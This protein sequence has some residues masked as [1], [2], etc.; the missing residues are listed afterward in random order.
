MFALNRTPKLLLATT[1]IGLLCYWILTAIGLIS[2]GKDPLLLAWNWSFVP[3]DVL[4]IAAG[5]LCS[6][7][8]EDH[9]WSV[10]LF[11]AALALTHAAGLM[12]VSFFA[13]WGTW[14]WSWWVVNVWLAV[15]PLILATMYIPKHAY[16]TDRN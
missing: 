6:V 7:L 5:L 10:P 9:R 14:D 2:V 13:L 3:L 8:P 1:D 11:I 4:A 15:I 12:A 16:W